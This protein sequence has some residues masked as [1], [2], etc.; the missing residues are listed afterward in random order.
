MPAFLVTALVWFLSGVVART[1]LGAGLAVG[2]YVLI[3]DF[4][5]DGLLYATGYLAGLGQ[6]GQLMY[7][8]GV[9]DA[10]SIVGSALVVAVTL[11]S[12][13]LFLVRS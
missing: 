7:L 10:M 3:E 1:L 6:I 5:N 2:S 4:V 9:G 13:R 11:Q 12:A 8:A